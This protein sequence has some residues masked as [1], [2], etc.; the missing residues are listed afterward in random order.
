[1]Q[2]PKN[3]NKPIT[4]EQIL[5]LAKEAEKVLKMQ[6]QIKELKRKLYDIEC[7]NRWLN[8]FNVAPEDIPNDYSDYVK[9]HSI[10]VSAYNNS[11]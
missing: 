5:K 6:K 11:K 10:L 1:M 3:L 2:R 4:H 7:E 8:N 9:A